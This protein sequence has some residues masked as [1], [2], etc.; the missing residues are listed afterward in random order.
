MKVKSPISCC[1]NH[2]HCSTHS[3]SQHNT[4]H[5]D[6]VTVGFALGLAVVTVGLEPVLR[7]TIYVYW[8]TQLS[9]VVRRQLPC[10]LCCSGWWQEGLNKKNFSSVKK[11]HFMSRTFSRPS[12][13]VAHSSCLNCCVPALRTCTGTWRNTLRCSTPDWPVTDVECSALTGAQVLAA[14]SFVTTNELF[15]TFDLCDRV[16]GFQLTSAGFAF[17]CINSLANFLHCTQLPVNDGVYNHY[18]LCPVTL[19][20]QRLHPHFSARCSYKVSE[21]AEFARCQHCNDDKTLLTNYMLIWMAN[22]D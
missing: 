13:A 10:W 11:T 1:M 12:R 8:K 15:S 7:G 19:L 9:A 14:L 22:N 18:H 6:S 17:S 5:W 3:V 20:M 21:C 16:C 4:N 2:V